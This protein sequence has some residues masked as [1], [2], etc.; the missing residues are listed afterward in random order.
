[1]WAGG[2]TTWEPKASFRLS[3]EPDTYCPA[4]NNFVE[5]EEH[6]EGVSEPLPEGEAALAAIPTGSDADALDEIVNNRALAHRVRCK[7]LDTE[8]KATQKKAR[9]LKAIVKGGVTVPDNRKQALE[10]EKKNN[11][12]I[13]ERDELGSFEELGVWKLVPLPRGR[14]AVGTRWVYDVK[15]DTEGVVEKYKARLVAQGFS[16]QQGID[17]NETF[18]PTMHIKTARV[19]VAL[20]ARLGLEIK[21]YDVSTAFLHASLAEEVYVKQ[22]PGHVTKGKEEWVYK[23]KKA[24]Y[25]LKNAPKAYSDHFMSLL[26]NLGFTQ[27]ASDECLWTLRKGEHFLHYLFHVDDI[28][29]VGNNTVLRETIMPPSG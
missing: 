10:S 27:S 21:Q 6:R 13:A 24:M 5:I 9:V 14:K 29:V 19:L 3:K 28:M 15:V 17:F 2:E 25:G 26:K 4:F 1:M 12:M 22:P 18:A 7:I 23:L 16:Q 11:F 20:A 8:S